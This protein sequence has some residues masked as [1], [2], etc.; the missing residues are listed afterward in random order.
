MFDLLPGGQAAFHRL[1]IDSQFQRLLRSFLLKL[2]KLAGLYNSHSLGRGGA[3]FAFLCGV[4]RE[5]IKALG[6]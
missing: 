3:T 1:L 2:E 5:L 6:V 4:P